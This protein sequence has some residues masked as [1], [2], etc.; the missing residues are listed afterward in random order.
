MAFTV[1]EQA[2]F[3]QPF[4]DSLRTQGNS[5][6]QIASLIMTPSLAAKKQY[7]F[8]DRTIEEASLEL[9]VTFFS[10][11]SDLPP[12]KDISYSLIVIHRGLD[13]EVSEIES[14]QRN[15]QAQLEW[16]KQMETAL[17]AFIPGLTTPMILIA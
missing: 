17:R 14:W 10:P 11:P 8:T 3:V 2:P 12:R 16:Y 6:I 5:T 15:S 13:E 4:L 1:S 9:S 7:G